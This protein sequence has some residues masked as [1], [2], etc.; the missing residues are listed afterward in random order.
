MEKDLVQKSSIAKNI[1]DANFFENISYLSCYCAL[2]QRI[3][4]EFGENT[5][6]RCR[7]VL[8]KM[9]DESNLWKSIDDKKALSRIGLEKEIGN[10]NLKNL[11]NEIE[12]CYTD[13]KRIYFFGSKEIIPCSNKKYFLLITFCLNNFDSINIHKILAHQYSIYPDKKEFLKKLKLC[14]SKNEAKL[15][16]IHKAKTVI[17]W[18]KIKQ[19]K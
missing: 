16:P 10:A 14:V 5:F 17:E 13:S 12:D 19:K 8:A 3:R 15:I 1:S 11:I 2:T 7:N 4:K 18:I 6:K 9:Q